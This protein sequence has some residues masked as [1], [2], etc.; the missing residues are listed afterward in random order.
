MSGMHE[1]CRVFGAIMVLA[2]LAG[3]VAIRAWGALTFMTIII[4]IIAV[5]ET[6]AS[7][8]CDQKERT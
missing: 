5:A 4:P 2:A 7:R 3:L 6:C 8:E 1:G